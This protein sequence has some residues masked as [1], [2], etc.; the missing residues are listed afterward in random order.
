MARQ[1]IGN[2]HLEVANSKK[3]ELKFYVLEQNK[4]FDEYEKEVLTYG[5]EIEKL[6]GKH[7]ESEKVEDITSEKERINEISKLLKENKVL[8]THLQDVIIDIL[9]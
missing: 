3:V 6:D 1:Y 4:Y 9:S 5:V 2:E 8:P 7:I